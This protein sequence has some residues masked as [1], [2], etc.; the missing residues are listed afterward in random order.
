MIVIHTRYEDCHLL[1]P[2]HVMLWMPAISDDDD[3]DDDDNMIVILMMMM[4]MMTIMMIMMIPYVLT[5][6]YH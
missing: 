3:D 2:F 1:Q 5:L 6:N 4:T